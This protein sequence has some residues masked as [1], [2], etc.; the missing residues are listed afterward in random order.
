MSSCGGGGLVDQPEIQPPV[1]SNNVRDLLSVLLTCAAGS[2]DALSL[3]GLGGVFASG[4]SGNTIVLGASLAQGESTKALLGIFIFI[5]YILGAA[6]AV[7]LL[8]GERHNTER[9]SSKVT[10]TLGIELV[11]LLTLFFGIYINH[12]YSSFN[13]GLVSLLIVASFSMGIQFVCAKHVNRFGVVTTVITAT[14][15]NLVSRLVSQTQP[16]STGM[17]NVST[18][19]N[20]V[21]TGMN[22]VESVNAAEG[23]KHT[24]W[25][26]RPS[27]TTLFLMITWAGYFTGA[28]S[29]GAA[30]FFSSRSAAAAIP[31]VLVLIVVSYAVTKELR[32]N[33]HK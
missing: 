19:M 26:G 9:L 20:N 22:N 10:Y 12:D 14:V 17:N 11:L 23:V 31:F 32:K 7:F 18:G 5:G 2:M 29:S 24:R 8:R 13:V 21:S 3:F 4:L 16:T 28:A 33:G 27:E 6:L 25:W 1:I 30:L 15:S